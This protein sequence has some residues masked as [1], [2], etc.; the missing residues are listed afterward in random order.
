MS[1]LRMIL[2]VHLAPDEDEDEGM[3]VQS[4]HD[5]VRAIQEIHGVTDVRVKHVK[6]VD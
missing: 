2:T 3:E 5:A 6:R 1:H 4:M